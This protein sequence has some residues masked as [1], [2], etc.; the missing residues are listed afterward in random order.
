MTEMKGVPLVVNDH[1]APQPLK[2]DL[3]MLN[4]GLCS[5]FLG[6]F[7][8]MAALDEQYAEEML[9]NLVWSRTELRD[10]SSEASVE[11]TEPTMA[12]DKAADQKGTVKT[13]NPSVTQS[14]KPITRDDLTKIIVQK[15]KKDR[16]NNEKIS[17]F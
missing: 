4:S 17:W 3:E 14:S 16:S 7:R 2:A 10:D 1:M 13:E 8:M 12:K 6:T 11:Q 15:I 9:R 5:V